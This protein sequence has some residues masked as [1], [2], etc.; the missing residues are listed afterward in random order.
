MIDFSIKIRA[1]GEEA[2]AWT[3]RGKRGA[4]KRLNSTMG[5]PNAYICGKNG[6]NFQ[7]KSPFYCQGEKTN[8]KKNK[9]GF[10]PYRKICVDTC[11]FDQDMIQ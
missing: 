7:E 11:K 4:S 9:K 8:E 6:G 1:G 10:F 5:M 3:K 2:E